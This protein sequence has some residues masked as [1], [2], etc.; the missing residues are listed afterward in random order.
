MTSTTAPARTGRTPR[1]A[2]PG[3]RARPLAGQPAADAAGGGAG[4]DD[5]RPGRHDRGGGQPG[6]PV[7]PARLPGRH[8]VDQQRLP[9]GPGGQPDPG[10]QGRGPVRPQE[11]LPHRG[12]RVRSQLGGHR[13]V[14]QHCRQHHPGHR[15]PRTAGR[16]RGDAAAHRPGPAAPDVPAGQ[17]QRGHRRVGRGHRRVHRGRADRRG[18]AGPAHRLGSLLLRQRP[19]RRRRPGH[20]PAR[21]EGDPRR[22]GQLVRHP[23]HRR[24]GRRAVHADLRPDQGPG[25]RLGL[26]PHAGLPRRRRP[27]GAAVRPPRVPAPASRCCP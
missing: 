14:R 17:A 22:P 4:G 16:V 27:A 3:G 25:L 21:A 24:P 20:E 2:A 1:P 7:P 26:R 10:R 11:G 6:H 12:G 23:R 5:G 9:A 13:P 8:P 15:V 19:G 18:A